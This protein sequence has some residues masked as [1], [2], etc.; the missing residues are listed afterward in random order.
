M[1]LTQTHFNNVHFFSARLT[2]FD[3]AN[4]VVCS[5]AVATTSNVRT[6]TTPQTIHVAHS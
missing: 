3:L 1:V 2:L 5:H 6:T 4:V